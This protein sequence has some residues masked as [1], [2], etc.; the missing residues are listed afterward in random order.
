MQQTKRKL[1]HV[2]TAILVKVSI[3]LNLCMEDTHLPAC[4]SVCPNVAPVRQVKREATLTGIDAA[5]QS[6]VF[7]Q[8]GDKDLVQLRARE[9]A[10]LHDNSYISH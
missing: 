7:V 6:L 4:P 1:H 2:D 9:T 8:R 3:I 5:V 10:C